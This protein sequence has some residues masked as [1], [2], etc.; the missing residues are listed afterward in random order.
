MASSEGTPTSS[1]SLGGK[2]PDAVR[3]ASC[4]GATDGRADGGREERE[5]ARGA[6]ARSR[7][8]PEGAHDDAHEDLPIVD[9]GRPGGMGD[10]GT[11]FASG[12]SGGGGGVMASSQAGSARMQ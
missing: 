7:P 2:L 11:G 4:R 6:S 8:D 1:G 9:D 3:Q 12:S 10:P 5:G